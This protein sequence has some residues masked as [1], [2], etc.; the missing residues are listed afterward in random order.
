ML[1]DVAQ[2]RKW[3]RQRDFFFSLQRPGWS[4][5]LSGSPTAQRWCHWSDIW[6]AAAWSF[7]FPPLLWFL[8]LDISQK[9][10]PI[11]VSGAAQFYYWQSWLEGGTWWW[12]GSI[13]VTARAPSSGWI[14]RLDLRAWRR[15]EQG[16]T[17]A[18]AP[19]AGLS[20]RSLWGKRVKVNYQVDQ[21][22][23]YIT[24]TL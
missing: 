10:K 14:L 4:L 3:C 7:G 9:L 20:W 6:S 8:K 5:A 2:W 13:R 23:G 21:D 24:L 19:P 15:K 18:L 16:S 22:D 12:A 1:L 11:M 17:A